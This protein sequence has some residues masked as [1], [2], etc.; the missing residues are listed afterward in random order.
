[1]NLRF[2]GGVREVGRSA[3]LVN[4]LLIDYGMKTSKPPQYPIDSTVEPDAVVASHGHLDHVGAIPTLMS[5]FPTVYQTPPTRDL[6]RLLAEDTLDITAHHRSPFSQED[7]LRLSQTA[8]THSYGERFE[9]AGFECEFRDAGH[10]P[11][12]ASVLVEGNETRLLYAGDINTTPT[13]LLSPASSPPSADT[14]VTDSTYFN[15]SHSDREKLEDEFVQSVR[16]TLYEGGNVVIPVFAI[17]RTQEILMVLERHDIPCYVD[18]MGT[19][20]TQIVRQYSEYLR[21]PDA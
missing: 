9:A 13:R 5:D 19:E 14:L 6:T 12:S 4:D 15:H 17:G 7:I 16:T 8:E 10:I 18:G 2:L 3:L 20:V 21:D 11:G 1:M